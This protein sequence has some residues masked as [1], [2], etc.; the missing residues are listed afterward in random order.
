M[1][2]L[3][4]RIH[5]LKRDLK[6]LWYRWR[7]GIKIGFNDSMLPEL[8]RGKYVDVA[9]K[10]DYLEIRD[11]CDEKKPFTIRIIPYQP[12]HGVMVEYVDSNGRVGWRTHADA[13]KFKEMGLANQEA[14]QGSKDR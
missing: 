10:G 9:R 3:G 7:H 6:A 5:W 2:R 4:I 13:R 1:T 11:H 8:G 14:P 12:N